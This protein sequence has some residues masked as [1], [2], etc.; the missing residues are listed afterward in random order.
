MEEKEIIA[1]VGQGAWDAMSADQR[2][3][4]SGKVAKP[5]EEPKPEPKKEE[6]KPEGDPLRDKVEAER[7]AKEEGQASTKRIESALK[8]NLGI[9]NFV[10]DNGDLL[11]SE[12]P[13]ILK[14]ADKENYDSAIQKANAVKVSF[15]QSFFSVKDHT[16]A[17]TASQKVQLDDFLKLTKNGKE[18]KAE[19]IYENL[20]EPAL[21]TIKKVKKAEELGK[22][23]TGF[24]SGTKVEDAYKAR[25]MNSSK[26][27][28]LG[29][30]G[31]S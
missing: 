1:M 31:A 7:K 2:T 11:P 17:L 3:A 21:E 8:F 20:F 9:A 18:E 19:A 29:E 10:K 24:A 23:R 28:Y 16:E 15:I 13:E 12:I 14:V 27:T 6:P 22:A 30:K 5:K 25:L 26:K 4:L